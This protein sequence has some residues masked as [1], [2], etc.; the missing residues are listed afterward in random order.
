MTDVV[1]ELVGELKTLRKGRG[2]FVGQI[3][4]RVGPILSRM[5][6]V[7]AHDGPAEIRKKVSGRLE[8]L[9][10]ELPEDLRL[11]VLA[12]FAIH[13]DARHPFYQERV[14]WVAQQLQRD[15]RTARRRIDEAI[16]RLA[17]LAAT[18]EIS[19][20]VAV[21]ASAPRWHTEELKVALMADRPVPE[22]LEFRRIIADQDDLE[23]LDLALTLS[24]PPEFSA[25]FGT[26]K[27]RVDVIYGGV[28]VPRA[29]ESLDRF[30]F[31][32]ELPHRL[33]RFGKHEFALR[34]HAD[35][36][37]P[38]RPHFGCVL[39][40]RCDLFDLRVRFDRENPPRQIRRL[41][42]AFHRDLEDPVP[43]GEVVTPDRAGELHLT[44]PHPTPGLVYGIRWD[45]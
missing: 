18:P 8:E 4:E 33:D 29:R 34:Y 26:R 42:G 15:E 3:G 37:W 28:L 10:G 44:F 27:L 43:H 31:A 11:A 17:E 1:T 32:L 7:V 5:C 20:G 14:R 24:V 41:D 9:A 19:R 22:A 38:M 40:Q 21:A 39:K 16:E 25:Q 45:G 23:E 6:G 13:R 12:A 35:D 2:L 30:G 36:R